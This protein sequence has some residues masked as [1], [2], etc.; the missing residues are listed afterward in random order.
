MTCLTPS[1]PTIQIQIRIHSIYELSSVAV[2]PIRPIQF[3]QDSSYRLGS[4]F[5]PVLRESLSI[6]CR[7]I[8]VP[9]PIGFRG[10]VVGKSVF[11][12]Q[13]RELEEG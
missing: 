6:T 8:G 7:H 2:M 13:E 3:S 10:S 11:V 5:L 1:L 12:R 4:L 9:F